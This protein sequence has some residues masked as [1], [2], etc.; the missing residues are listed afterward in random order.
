MRREAWFEAQ[1]D[2]DPARLVFVD[3][4]WAELPKVPRAKRVE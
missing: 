3:E 2:L 4:S 1:T